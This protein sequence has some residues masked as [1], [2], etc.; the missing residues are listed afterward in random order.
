MAAI[1]GANIEQNDQ[2]PSNKL[3]AASCNQ[4]PRGSA[5]VVSAIASLA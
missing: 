2:L 4:R 1:P 3:A 5:M